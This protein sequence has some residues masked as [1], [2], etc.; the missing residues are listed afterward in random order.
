[1]KEQLRDFLDYLR[2]NRNAS[3]HTIS[4]YESDIAQYLGFVAAD[5]GMPAARLEP[6]ALDLTT[7]RLF[8]AE[9]HRQGQ[10]RASVA[11]KL[12]AL[13]AFSRFL[14]REGWIEN[15]PAALAVSPRR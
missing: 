2:L 6:E 7:I 11:R 12:S 3:D 8:M 1:M 15:D 4:A 10:S 5:A 14:R 13:R 9:L